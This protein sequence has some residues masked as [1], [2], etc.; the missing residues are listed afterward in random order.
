MN[1]IADRNG[2]LAERCEDEGAVAEWDPTIHN[3]K[4]NLLNPRHLVRPGCRRLLDTLRD[5]SP[6]FGGHSIRLRLAL[7][8]FAADVGEVG[9]K[10]LPRA[11]LAEDLLRIPK[12]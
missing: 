2:Q 1:I 12:K 4:T 11:P 7:V 10:L 9:R 3:A 6:V 5:P 8:E